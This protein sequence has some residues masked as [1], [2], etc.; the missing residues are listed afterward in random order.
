MTCSV[1][2]PGNSELY[3]ELNRQ[4]VWLKEFSC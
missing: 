1:E 4:F 3:D 2:E